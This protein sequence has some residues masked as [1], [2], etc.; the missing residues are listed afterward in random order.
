MNSRIWILWVIPALILNILDVATTG[1]GLWAGVGQEANPMVAA[2]IERCGLFSGL[3][4]AFV[5]KIMEI[6]VGAVLCWA[7]TE[8]RKVFREWGFV[9]TPWFASALLYFFLSLYLVMMALVVLNN[10]V[11]LALG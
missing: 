5:I 7:A 4:L 10:F 11:V 3:L 8:S 1:V 6:A 2:L 9:L